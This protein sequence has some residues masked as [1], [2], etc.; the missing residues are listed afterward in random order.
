MD[1]VGEMVLQREKK[2]LTVIAI[3]PVPER[4]DGNRVQ[5]LLC[6][7]HSSLRGFSLQLC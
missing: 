2:H 3:K 4:C 1:M 6:P 7:I 5:M